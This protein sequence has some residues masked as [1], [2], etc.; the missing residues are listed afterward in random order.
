M[1]EFE[2]K[3]G[4]KPA[5]IQIEIDALDRLITRR[6]MWLNKPESK[7]KGTYRAVLRDTEEMEAK[8]KALRIEFDEVKDNQ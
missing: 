3:T 8:L 6:W 4:R 5:T 1:Q 7:L 2:V